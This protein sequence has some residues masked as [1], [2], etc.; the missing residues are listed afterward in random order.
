[1]PI[2]LLAS[3]VCTIALAACGSSAEAELP[4]KD[5]AGGVKLVNVGKFKMPLYVTAPPK[6]PRRAMVVQQGG[7][8]SV[9]RD[10][11]TLSTPFLDVSSRLIAGGEQGLLGLAFAPG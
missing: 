5:A 9:V 3:L 2:A 4:A 6:D 7:R 1:M 10:G 8:I 11:K